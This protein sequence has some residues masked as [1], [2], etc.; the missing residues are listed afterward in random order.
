MTSLRE[1]LTHVYQR[2]TKET[3]EKRDET[4]VTPSVKFTIDTSHAGEKVKSTTVS[5]LEP[6]KPADAPTLS[7]KDLVPEQDKY[8]FESQGQ[9]ESFK[10]DRIE[11]VLVEREMDD[12]EENA[13]TGTD[14]DHE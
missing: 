11:F 5:L 3:R 14:R 2:K 4:R 8:G 12:D 7:L 9:D 1:K 6:V 13:A 10:S